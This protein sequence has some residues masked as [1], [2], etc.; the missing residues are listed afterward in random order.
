V[1]R[2]FRNFAVRTDLARFPCTVKTINFVGLYI[3]HMLNSGRYPWLLIFVFLA[4]NP[5]YAQTDPIG[6]GRAISF[7]GVDDYID[8]GDVYAD[9]ELP[10]TI[11]GW[12]Y[13]DPSNN[14]AAPIFANRN[15]D[16]VYT[17]FRLIVNNNAISMDYGD[18]LGGNNPA[19][20]RGK[21]ANVDLLT[22]SWNHITAVVKG[23]SDM[24]LY[25]NGINVGGTYSGSSSLPMDS[26]KP[27][28]GSTAYFISNGVI[29]RFKGMIDDIRLWD[30]ALSETE[31][32]QTM[33]VNLIGNESGLIGY[34]NFNET[35]G[36]TVFD[37]SST[38]INGSFV[39]NP[40]RVYSGA[41]IGDVSTN[42]YSSNLVGEIISLEN[43]SHKLDVSNISNSA[44]GVQVYYVNNAPSQIGGLTDEVADMYFGVFLARQN[45]S[46]TFDAEYSNSGSAV[47]D[48]YSRE[49]NSK[50]AWNK[51]NNPF[52]NQPKRFELIADG[53]S[54]PSFD[55]GPDVSVCGESGYEI[56]TGITGSE[57]S[58]LWNTSEE[59][60][61]IVVSESGKY[62][63]SVSNGCST[64]KDSITI[65]FVQSPG[66]FSLGEDGE[67]C[68]FSPVTLKAPNDSPSYTYL[69]QDGSGN[70]TYDAKDFGEY[71][72][73]VKN[74]CGEA[75]DSIM[76]S[77][78]DFSA[79]TVPN[80]ITPN[81]D[82]KNDYFMLDE[83][84]VGSAT[85]KVINRWGKEV[86]YADSY[87][88]K[89]NANDLADGIYFFVLKAPCIGTNKGVLHILK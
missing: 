20:R 78:P 52:T 60:S 19:F 35:D 40:Q 30:R 80:V 55:L 31:I 77:K 24:N 62:S 61:A 37:M 76:F 36:N 2:S 11:S 42:F 67:S 12:V 58:I 26:S 22:G 59:T 51:I 70:S 41:P 38:G 27:G 16:P 44:Q 89:W 18:G 69:W 46:N 5:L 75:S 88:N 71:W 73:V 45:G 43:G 21:V 79:G 47:C 14:Q 84:L 64:A 81:D 53:G 56:S 85:L 1:R 10:F 54:R 8:Y 32:R 13:L 34:W 15:C 17:G 66:K 28:F 49:D 86:Y 83:H 6:S 57:F 3:P 23:P 29:Y 74:V 25:L 50:P 82:G 63:V 39:G 48:P 33:C 65:E 72:V 9:L 68:S 7:D 87:E 4:A